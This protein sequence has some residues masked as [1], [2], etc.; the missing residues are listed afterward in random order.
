MISNFCRRI[1]S[2]CRS[3]GSSLRTDGAVLYVV[4]ANRRRWGQLSGKRNDFYGCSE[5]LFWVDEQRV[6][7]MAPI[8]GLMVHFYCYFVQTHKIHYNEY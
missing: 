8:G 4:I 6:D 3:F 7:N 1:C 2:F 5:P